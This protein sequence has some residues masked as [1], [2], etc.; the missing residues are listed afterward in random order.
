M[1]CISSVG[2]DMFLSYLT[3]GHDTSVGNN[4]H[5]LPRNVLLLSIPVKSSAVSLA[6]LLP[7]N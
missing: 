5:S 1:Q 2:L 3:F 4:C 6:D 7:E